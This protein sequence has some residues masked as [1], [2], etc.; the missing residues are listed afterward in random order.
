MNGSSTVLTSNVSAFPLLL[1]S[2]SR[3]VNQILTLSLLQCNPYPGGKIGHNHRLSEMRTAAKLLA[4]HQDRQDQS[5]P[6]VPGNDGIVRKKD[7]D[8]PSF[9]IR[10]DLI[11]YKQLLRYFRRKKINDPIGWVKEQPSYDFVLSDDAELITVVTAASRTSSS[12]EEALKWRVT[13]NSVW[14]EDDDQLL[15][16]DVDDASEKPQ[17]STDD[18]CVDTD[19][20]IGPQLDAPTSGCQ[21]LHH[22]YHSR[23]SAPIL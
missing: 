13:P 7:A 8:I 6:Q 21:A 5:I 2:L 10:R 15:C 12:D 16:T 3:Y 11:S 9:N 1:R 18:L 4:D 20:D 17:W 14:T 23:I 22:L 19:A